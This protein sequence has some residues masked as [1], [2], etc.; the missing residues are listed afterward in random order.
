MTSRL[1][2][3]PLRSGESFLLETDHN[4]ER[5]V[6][7]VDGGQSKE[8]AP[9]KNGLYGAIRE[10]CP[11]VTERIDVAI[12]THRD[13]DHAGGFPAFINAWLSDGKEIGEFWL[14]GGWSSAVELALTNPDKLV[15]M[16]HEG[17]VDAANM[18][19]E[20]DDARSLET[21][22]KA[23]MPSSGS[24][25]TSVQSKIQQLAKQR[26]DRPAKLDPS[27]SRVL[28]KATDAE[29]SRAQRAASSWGF[30][31]KDWKAIQSDLETSP[32]QEETLSDRAQA[33]GQLASRPFAYRL[34]SPDGG[35]YA[36]SLVW[37]V[38]PSE[39]THLQTA[40]SLFRSTIDTA[41]AIRTIASAAVAFDI[42]VR[43][44]DFSDFEDGSSP[45][46][47][48]PNFLTPLNAV[49]QIDVDHVT[50]P[51]ILF[52]RLSLTEQNVSSLVFQ[53]HETITEPSVI[54]LADSRLAFGIDRPEHDFE[55]YLSQPQRAV[56]YTAPHHGSRNNDHAYGVLAK[57]LSKL[58]G[59]SIAL[60]NG[61]VW[62]QTLEDYLKVDRRL[63]AQC[64]Q[65]H[66][67]HWS[68]LAQVVTNGADWAWPAA[69]GT[70]CGTPKRRN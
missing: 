9:E 11:E 25:F 2:A 36:Y 26:R 62:N 16:I 58:F 8:E 13:H 44:F 66:G 22:P 61:G 41:E 34:A 30:S 29:H 31:L 46:G 42:P 18:I 59:D 3:L 65:C 4:G 48:I 63:C 20:M 55:N 51:L 68:Q 67:G 54:F 19:R 5:W 14:P 35:R 10:S 60:R 21:H 12:C 47:G 27:V 17:A 40:R 6:V 52:L 37:S 32:F 15:S 70:R 56:A 45:S 1:T 53:R 7:L 23:L 24:E 49:E 69:Q 38:D 50:D 33:L 28:L 64:S 39:I 57:W 43:W